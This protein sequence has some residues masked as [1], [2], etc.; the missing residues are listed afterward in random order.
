VGASVEE[1]NTIVATAADIRNCAI[2]GLGGYTADDPRR[3]NTSEIAIVA[4]LAKDVFVDERK[5]DR[6]A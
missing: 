1:A 3:A 4:A 5:G 6:F 2:Y